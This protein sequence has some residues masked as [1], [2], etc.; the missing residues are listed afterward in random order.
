VAGAG[1]SCS[2]AGFGISDVENSCS[3]TMMFVH[4]LV[5]IHGTVT[6]HAL[7]TFK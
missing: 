2:K 6:A 4:L 3:T 1:S 5:G 7:C